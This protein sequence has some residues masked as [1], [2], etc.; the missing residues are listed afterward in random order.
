M[1]T[2]PIL[3]LAAVCLLCAHCA[4]RQSPFTL[5]QVAPNVWAAVDNPKA[6]PSSGSNAGVVIGDTGVAVIDTFARSDAAKQ[7]LIEIH[8][9]TPH[10]TRRRRQSPGRSRV[11]GLLDDAPAV[12]RR[13]ATRRQVRCCSR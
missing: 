6:Q 4:R 10:R 1:N 12:G 2:A 11:P 5:K 8:R 3:L 7:L 9:L 13:G